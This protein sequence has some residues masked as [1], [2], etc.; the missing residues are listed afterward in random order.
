MKIRKGDSI[1]VISGKDRGKNGTI[2]RAFPKRDMVLIEGVNI[3]KRHQKPRKS[4][5][6]GQIVEKPMPIH[7]SNVAIKD[8]KTNKPSRVRYSIDDKGT[9]IRMTAKSGTKI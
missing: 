1:I 6:Q 9:K 3:V 7:V 4:G 5:Q 8:S 2:L